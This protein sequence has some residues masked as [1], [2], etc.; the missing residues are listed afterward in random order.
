MGLDTRKEDF[1]HTGQANPNAPRPTVEEQYPRM[2]L[3]LLEDEIGALDDKHPQLVAA[4]ELCAPVR[5]S[6]LIG[7]LLT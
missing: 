7:Q 6:P 4:C 1:A 2:A 5:C 3:P